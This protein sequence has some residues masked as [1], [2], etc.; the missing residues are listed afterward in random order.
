MKVKT[1]L[2]LRDILT[3][4]SITRFQNKAI[5]HIFVNQLI[6][7]I[8]SIICV[9]ILW[10]DFGLSSDNC[11]SPNK[12]LWSLPNPSWAI[13]QA[14]FLQAW[15]HPWQAKQI[16][17]NTLKIEVVAFLSVGPNKALFKR[18]FLKTSPDWALPSSA[19]TCLLNILFR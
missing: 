19:F 2:I 12:T 10:L 14:T 9:R 1:W 16:E 15:P 3:F 7:K 13:I 17:L 4:L 11:C 8:F 5:N 18:N 6:F